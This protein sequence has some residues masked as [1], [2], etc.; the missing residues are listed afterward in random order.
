MGADIDGGDARVRIV[1]GL[2]R[3]GVEL[4]CP[5][6]ARRVRY[7]RSTGQSAS[8]SFRPASSAGR[9]LLHRL[10]RDEGSPPHHLHGRDEAAVRQSAELLTGWH[11]CHRDDIYQKI[12]NLSARGN[13]KRSVMDSLYACQGNGPFSPYSEWTYQGL[14]HHLRRSRPVAVDDPRSLTLGIRDYSRN[15]RASDRARRRGRD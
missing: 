4:P 15:Q 1:E 11:S 14:Q 5:F 3:T 13:P 10:A 12:V 6:R 7:A 8:M 9:G 2:E